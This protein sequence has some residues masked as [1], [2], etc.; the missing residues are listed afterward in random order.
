MSGALQGESAGLPGTVWDQL[1]E[2]ERE[3]LRF[4][5]GRFERMLADLEA[6]AKPSMRVG[7]VGQSLFD[8]IAHERLRVTS[9]QCIV[10]NP[11]FSPR[12]PVYSALPR[13]YFDVTADR[14]PPEVTFDLVVFA[15]VL[16]HLLADDGVV[17]RRVRQLVT[18]GGLLWMSVPNALR[19]SNRFGV[20]VGRNPF[21][22]KQ[23]ILG[24]TFGGYGH[25][26]EYSLPELRHLLVDAGFQILRVW[27]L[28]GYGTAGQ[29]AALNLLPVSCA[30]TLVAWAR[31]PAMKDAGRETDGTSGPPPAGW[32]G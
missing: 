5:R 14:G 30:S 22:P 31:A 11:E 13:V 6:I 15:E 7:N 2:R 9:Y 10:P 20:P 32:V 25:I 8:L 3:Y 12:S 27:G 19:F 24:G 4:G 1:T 16:E 29:R 21:P 28:N 23:K 26:R 17:M 18:P